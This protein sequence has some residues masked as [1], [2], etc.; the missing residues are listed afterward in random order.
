M[1]VKNTK[2]NNI[3][4]FPDLI[5]AKVPAIVPSTAFIFLF[6]YRGGWREGEKHQYVVASHPPLLGTWP[7]TQACALTGNWTCGPSVHRPALKPL[8]HTKPGCSSGPFNVVV[9]PSF[10]TQIGVLTFHLHLLVAFAHPPGFLGDLAR[11][12]VNAPP[13]NP[14][15]LLGP[16]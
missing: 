13:P 8:S 6:L 14:P 2:A 10:Y 4:W 12:G 1:V 3:L 5:H 11:Q 7:S 15:S 9:S 16:L